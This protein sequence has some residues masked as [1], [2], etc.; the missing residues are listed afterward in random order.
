VVE[1]AADVFDKT[2]QVLPGR[3]R[4]DRA[5]ENVI[6]EQCRHRELGQRTTHRFLDHPVHAAADEHAAGF[7]IKG[8]HRVT[9]QHDGENEPGSAFADH[10]LGVTTRVIGGRS[11]VGKHD[12]SRPPEGDEGQ[13]HRSGDENLNGRT[14][15]VLNG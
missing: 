15:D 10:F 9:E 3:N 7:D 14:T 11:Q 8:P 4:A 5:G 1:I 13:H 2:R 12:R 6:K